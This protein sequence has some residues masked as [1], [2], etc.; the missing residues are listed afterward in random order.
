MKISTNS[1]WIGEKQ[2]PG[3]EYSFSNQTLFGEREF[4]IYHDIVDDKWYGEVID[5]DGWH[6]LDPEELTKYVT[7]IKDAVANGEL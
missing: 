3:I 5:S 4:A 2:N 7:I 1:A 6:D